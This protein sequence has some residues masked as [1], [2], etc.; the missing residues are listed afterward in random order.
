M[1]HVSNE[2]RDRREYSWAK[3]SKLLKTERF[4]KRDSLYVFETA[5]RPSPQIF[6]H[7]FY[8]PQTSQTRK[9]DATFEE[10]R[11]VKRREIVREF[12]TGVHPEMR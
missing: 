12:L 1:G 8:C 3:N 11:M 9:F 5:E 2:M 6:R 7:I 4:P 10:H